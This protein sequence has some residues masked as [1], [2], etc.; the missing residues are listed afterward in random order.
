MAMRLTLVKGCPLNGTSYASNFATLTQQLNFINSFPFKRYTVNT[1]RLGETIR[2]GDSVSNLMGYNYGYID[3]GDGFCYFIAVTSISMV[4][5]TQSEITYFVDAYETVCNQSNLAFKQCYI[6]RY[7]VQRGDVHLSTEPYYW[8][9][10]HER[11]LIAGCTFIA[12]ASVEA[13]NTSQC[14]CF[15]IPINTTNNFREVL[16]GDWINNVNVNPALLPSDVYIACICPF[17]LV[18]YSSAIWTNYAKPDTSLPILGSPLYK[19]LD[20]IDNLGFD[21]LSSDLFTRGQIR[22]MRNN[23]VWEC[24]VGRTYN[25]QGARLVISATACNVNIK[26]VDANNNVDYRVINIP[27]EMVDIYDDSWKE[28]QGRQRDTDKTLRQ[29]DYNKEAL[30]GLANIVNG[31][32]TGSMAGSLS[33]AGGGLGAIAGVAGGLIGT[34][35]T[36]AINQYYDP[37][38]QEQYD[39]SYARQEDNL[40]LAGNVTEDMYLNNYAGKVNVYPDPISK[41]QYDKEFANYGYPTVLYLDSDPR[42]NGNERV[43]GCIRGSVNITADCPADW[44]TQIASRFDMGIYFIR[45]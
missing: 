38:Y 22:D 40:L 18:N 34:L 26:L 42:I 6:T 16:R 1:V 15:V 36:Y 5:E 28:Y 10:N 27:C 12:L 23:V 3:Y 39:R 8:Y 17:P 9:V 31:G 20:W 30:S 44:I 43:V 29:M 24:P 32:I 41:A 35:G 4:T 45:S 21:S 25:V 37:K 7:P 11:N 2:L 13:N 14:Y 33:S 19:S